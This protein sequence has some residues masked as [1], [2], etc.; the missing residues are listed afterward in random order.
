MSK[1]HSR[2]L[3]PGQIAMILGHSP[4]LLAAAGAEDA[5]LEMPVVEIVESAETLQKFPA[6]STY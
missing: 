3:I 5:E 1:I 4:I 6:P 2:L